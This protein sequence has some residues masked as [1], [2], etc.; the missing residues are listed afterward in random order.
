LPGYL[1]LE[2]QLEEFWNKSYVNP[3]NSS[4]GNEDSMMDEEKMLAGMLDSSKGEDN[5]KM[6]TFANENQNQSNMLNNSN[7]NEP[8]SKQAF[9]LEKKN[10]AMVIQENVTGEKNVN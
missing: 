2:E 3:I 7:S 6:N 8:L 9:S 10:E 1:E 4:N 5:K